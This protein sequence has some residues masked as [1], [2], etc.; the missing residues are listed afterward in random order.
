MLLINP[1]R[2]HMD[3]DGHYVVSTVSVFS[4]YSEPMC[5][6]NPKAHENHDLL[7]QPYDYK[8]NI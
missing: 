5:F 6:H 1:L 2:S 4:G 3:E 7:T 8:Q